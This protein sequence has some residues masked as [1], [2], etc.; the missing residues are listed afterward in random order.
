MS[1]LI[2]FFYNTSYIQGFVSTL[3]VSNPFTFVV[4]FVG[5]QGTIE[6]IVCFVVASILSRALYKILKTNM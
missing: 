2:I 6:A 5:V 3:G 4:A 1:S